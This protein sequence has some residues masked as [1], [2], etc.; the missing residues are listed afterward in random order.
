MKKHRVASY[1]LVVIVLLWI[2]AANPLNLFVRRSAH[3]SMKKFESIQ[4]GTKI[5][6]AISLLGKPVI[7]RKTSG[8]ICTDC[9]AYHFLGDPPPWLLCYR[10]A[11]LLV[12]SHGRVVDAIVN[13]EP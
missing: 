5:E 3:F 13:S 1:L 10:E 9:T 12:D 2:G 8:L 6:K 4:R 11:W 7:V